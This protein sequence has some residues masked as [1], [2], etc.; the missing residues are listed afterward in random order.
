MLMVNG[1]AS[2]FIQ[3]SNLEENGC[4]REISLKD[5]LGNHQWGE[6]GKNHDQKTT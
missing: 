3:L 1:E 4:F 2:Y 5:V 6:V